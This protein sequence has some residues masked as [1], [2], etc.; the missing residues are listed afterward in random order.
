M[1]LLVFSLHIVA[2][3]GHQ[4]AGVDRWSER[5]RMT[6]LGVWT[7]LTVAIVAPTLVRL[8]QIRRATRRGPPA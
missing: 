1:L 6:Y 3:A 8:R 7:A 2:I 4:L 5:W